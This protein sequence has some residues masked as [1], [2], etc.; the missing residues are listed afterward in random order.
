MIEFTL[1]F[2]LRIA[3]IIMVGVGGAIVAWFIKEMFV[4]EARKK[5]KIEES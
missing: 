2:I 4:K 5:E 3:V 1:S